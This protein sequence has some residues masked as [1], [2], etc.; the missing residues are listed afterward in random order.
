MAQVT[1]RASDELVERVREVAARESRSMNEFLTRVME[2][3]TD[4]DLAG[5]EVARLRERLARAGLLAPP[6]LPRQRPD[7]ERLAA[8][9]RAAGEGTAL[10]DLVVRDRG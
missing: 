8:A 2:A 3:V 5:D 4:P 6:G 9:R 1:W 10:A 7:G